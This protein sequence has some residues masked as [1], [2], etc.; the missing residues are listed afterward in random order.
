MSRSRAVVS[1][2]SRIAVS[3]RS[4]IAVCHARGSRCVT[5]EER[6][7]DR[8]SRCRE[9][10]QATEILSSTVFHIFAHAR[11]T[12]YVKYGVFQVRAVY[13]NQKNVMKN[14]DIQ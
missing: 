10:L 5:I 6:C 11:D 14:G 9:Q 13:R 8:G 4:R 12:V 1:R 2:R 3:R 7:C